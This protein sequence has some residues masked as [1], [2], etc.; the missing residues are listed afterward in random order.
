M[1]PEAVPIVAT[2]SRPTLPRRSRASPNNKTKRK[3]ILKTPGATP[4]V[5]IIRKANTKV[6]YPPW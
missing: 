6:R 1:E 5:K 3:W 2:P 4:R